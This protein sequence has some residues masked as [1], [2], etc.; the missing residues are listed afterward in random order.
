MSTLT[1][2]TIL[3][4]TNENG[5]FIIDADASNH[6]LGAVLSQVQDGQERV[7]AYYSC[8][9]TESELHYCVTSKRYSHLYKL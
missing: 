4:Y 2:M 3:G 9:L 6:G 8:S 1:L 7:I 5:K